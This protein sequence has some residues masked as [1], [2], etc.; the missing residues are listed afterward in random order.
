MI[1]VRFCEFSFPFADKLG[2][3]FTH[4]LQKNTKTSVPFLFLHNF[5]LFSFLS[6]HVYMVQ[7][8]LYPMML[9]MCH[10]SSPSFDPLDPNLTSS[11]ILNPSLVDFFL[12]VLIVSFFIC[13]LSS[14]SPS[15][16]TSSKVSHPI[17]A[18][19]TSTMYCVISS[20]GHWFH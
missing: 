2:Q 10:Y 9:F 7:K 17:L 6:S 1:Y 19:P 16:K 18:I 12:L 15:I 3:R 8:Q 20:N 4:T 11:P 14:S 5:I 13:V